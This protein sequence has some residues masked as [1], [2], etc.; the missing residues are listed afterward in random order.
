MTLSVR[1]P[2][3]SRQT[4][5]TVIGVGWLSIVLAVWICVLPLVSSASGQQHNPWALPGYEQMPSGPRPWAN[6]PSPQPQHRY[7]D[8]RPPPRHYDY[9]PGYPNYGYYAPPVSPYDG[10]YPGLGNP[11]SPYMAPGYGGMN[12]IYPGLYGDPFVPGLLPTLPV[13]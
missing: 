1:I 10:L 9:Q 7:R 13:W 8:T 12:G 11:Y 2:L 5:E 3:Q 4:L 6:T